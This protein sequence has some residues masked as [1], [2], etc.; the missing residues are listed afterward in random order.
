[1]NP[2]ADRL[3]R[4]LRHAGRPG[5]ALVPVL[6]LA[7]AL[8]LQGV[9]WGLPYTFVNP[10]EGTV[11]PKAVHVAL[12]H[13]NPDFFYYP[14][15]FFYLVAGAYWLVAPFWWLVT[16]DWIV[17]EG[18]FVVDSGPHYLIARLLVVT[19]A[20][21]SVYLVYR[22][23]KAA[24]SPWVG[25]LAA[26]F[27]AVE[28]LHAKYSHMAVTD[29][30]AVTLSLLALLLLLQAAQGDPRRLLWGAVAAGLATSTKYNLGML[31]LPAVAAG[32]YAVQPG[33]R[34]LGLRGAR[35]ARARAGVLARRVVLPM[36][37]AFLVG[38][39]FVLLDLPLFLHDFLR[40]GRI[41]QRGWLGFE[42]VGNTYWYN[43]S[44]NLAGALGL[45]LLALALGG[46]LLAFWRHTRFDVMVAPYLIVTFLYVSSW[47][48][49]ADRYV[50]PLVPLLLLLGARLCVAALRL[51]PAT[52]PRLAAAMRPALAFVLA[53]TVIAAAVLPLSDSI[54]FNRSLAG[55]DVR[56]TAKDWVERN[57]P[58]GSVIAIDTYGPPLVRHRDARYY[59][60]A[61]LDPV[62]Y[63]IFK[64]KLPVPGEPDRRHSLHFLRRRAVE[65]V[66]VTSTV[67]DRI[68]A[69]AA[70]YPRLARFYERLGKRAELVKIF[71]P[72]PGE[73]GP[74]IKLYQ[75]SDSQ[76]TKR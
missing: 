62:A 75:L 7:L 43:F 69:A 51:R 20:L 25:V 59:H 46:L 33:I 24:Y 52:R 42:Q 18:A 41:V 64:L 48:E 3:A 16:G 58:K 57:L 40:Q 54:A 61:G 47:K 22:L 4:P 2:L 35:A 70:D 31:L 26:L 23:G 53:G 68:L 76:L 39:P 11:V 45:V 30:P 63:R 13:L 36:L 44:V 28:P 38:S 74:V 12:G 14:S 27:V 32:L 8:R 71:R 60:A 65:Y 21:V 1:M 6:L 49:L 10:D 72:Q 9:A 37:A 5:A 56:V 15:F 19:L 29:V 34:R 17:S 73:R 67:Y 55:Q 50:L 66:I